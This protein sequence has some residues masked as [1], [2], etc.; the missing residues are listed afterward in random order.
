MHPIGLVD[1]ARNML[2]DPATEIG[3]TRN[4]SL[5]VWDGLAWVPKGVHRFLNSLLYEQILILNDARLSLSLHT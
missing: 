4:N 1:L 5:A 2:S 3:K